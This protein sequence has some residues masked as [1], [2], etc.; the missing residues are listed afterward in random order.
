MVMICIGCFSE[1]V[2]LVPLY[3]SDAHTVVDKF[4]SIVVS[5]HRLLECII[6]DH[7]PHFHGHFC[8]EL[9][10]L[11]DI[12]LTFRMVFHPQTNGMA[13]VINHTI[14]QLL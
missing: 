9:V 4:L 12:T 2:K 5:Q 10:F 13:K 8:D 7:D 6:S 14:E 1:I 3:E 11:L